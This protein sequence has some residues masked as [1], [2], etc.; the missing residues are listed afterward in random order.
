MAF[1]ASFLSIF[2]K[3]DTWFSASMR[4]NKKNLL[5]DS[6]ISYKQ[7]DFQ[8]YSSFTT[9]YNGCCPQEI[10]FY[11]PFR[12]LNIFLITIRFTDSFV[13][14]FC[15]LFMSKHTKQIV[16][17]NMT[18]WMWMSI[19]RRKIRTKYSYNK[20]NQMHWFLKFIFGIKLYMFRAVPLSIIRSFHWTHS[21][22]IC[23]NEISQMGKISVWHIPL[24]WVQ[25]KTPD[26]GQRNSPKHV[27]FYYQNK[28]EK[29]VPLVGL[30]IRIYQDARSPERQNKNEVVVCECVNSSAVAYLTSSDEH[31]SSAE[32]NIQN[33][34]LLRYHWKRKSNIRRD[35]W[36]TWKY[37]AVYVGTSLSQAPT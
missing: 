26:D 28:F 31:G 18:K 36:K 27:E 24:L 11:S 16:K 1:V 4:R 17:G 15:Y 12:N 14:S 6:S 2:C 21:N 23:H 35:L 8:V 32:I 33:V 10:H 25:W 22:G 30:F 5:Y 13:A 19:G 29:S 34:G 37:D 7:I 3:S 9:V 20:T